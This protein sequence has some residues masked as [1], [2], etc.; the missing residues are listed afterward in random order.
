MR[1]KEVSKTR[2]KNCVFSSLNSYNENG[3]RDIK[4]IFKKS[5]K[6]NSIAIIDKSNYLRKIRNNLSDSSKVTLKFL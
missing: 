6:G 3:I 5:G 1:K 4:T 2:T